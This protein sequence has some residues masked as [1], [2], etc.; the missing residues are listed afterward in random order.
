MK[1]AILAFAFMAACGIAHGASTTTVPIG[2]AEIQLSPMDEQ[3]I[4]VKI[5]TV[6]K[7]QLFKDIEAPGHLAFDPELYTAQTDYSEALQQLERVKNS[8]LPDVIHSARHMLQSAKLRLKILGLSDHQIAS[9][10]AGGEGEANLLLTKPGQKVWIYADIF[11]MDLPYVHSGQTA[12]ITAEFLG[13]KTLKGKIVSV[14]RVINS[15]TQ[16]AKARILVSEGS[17]YLRPESYVNVTIHSPLGEQVTVPFD[18]LLDTGKQS[19]V[20]IA[21]SLGKI[22]PRLVR[23]KFYAGD[24]AAI[25]SGLRGG[26]KIVTSA[27]F[28]IDS[29]SR[30]KAVSEGIGA[31]GDS[32]KKTALPT[33]SKGQ[34]WDLSMSMCMPD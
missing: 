19:W 21:S 23:V 11:Q 14:D 15:S 27:N 17:S 20:F 28:L 32:G 1:N 13:G 5:G 7:K 30:L 26:E 2:H 8:P 6:E 9:L 25:A 31:P 29:E 16:T 34:H 22:A 4:G 3:L 10:Q 12:N 33:C 24:D 18:A